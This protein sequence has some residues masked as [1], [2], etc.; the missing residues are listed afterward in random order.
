M[1]PGNEEK[2]CFRF[3]VSGKVQGVYF[4][5]STR[6]QADSLGITG[7]A[8][9]LPNGDVEVLACGNKAQVDELRAWLWKGPEPAEVTDVK[10]EQIVET[11]LSNFEI[12]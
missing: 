5:A 6:Y 10:S 4:R 7:Y 9:N 1:N 12:I 8:R 2:I 11:V 3:H